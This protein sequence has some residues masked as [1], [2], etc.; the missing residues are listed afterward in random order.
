MD[1]AAADVPTAPPAARPGHAGAA[2]GEPMTLARRFPGETRDDPPE[3]G[4][5]EEQVEVGR[6]LVTPLA[7]PERF[8]VAPQPGGVRCADPRV[9]RVD[10][11]REPVRPAP[12]A[13]AR[14]HRLADDLAGDRVG[15]DGLEAVAHLDPELPVLHE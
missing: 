1:E 2:R 15:D 4:E 10:G 5:E 14:R 6:V 11:G 9:D 3:E 8:G 7:P 12:F 13:E